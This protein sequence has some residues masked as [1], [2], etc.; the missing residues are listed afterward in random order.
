MITHD[1]IMP[2]A[3]A[4]TPNIDELLAPLN[5]VIRDATPYWDRYREAAKVQFCEWEGQSSDGRMW[6]KRLG[7]EPF[8]WDGAHDLRIR[9]ANEVVDETKD[10][11]LN[12]F[13][14]AEVQAV[15]HQSKGLQASALAT[16]TLRWLL[17]TQ[18]Q[19]QLGQEL[20]LAAEWRQGFGSAV[21]HVGW[22]RCV[23]LMPQEMSLE[24]LLAQSMAAQME[25]L[26]PEYQQDPQ[27][28]QMVQ[29]AA[30]QSV[31]DFR[32]SLSDP[33]QLEGLAASMRLTLL[34]HLTTTQIRAVLEEVRDTGRGVYP[35]PQTYLSQPVW[36]ALRPL[37][38][39]FFPLS[40]GDLSRS[41]WVCRM[42]YYNTDQLQERVRTEEWDQAW[43][44]AVVADHLGREFSA[45]VQ[46]IRD[47]LEAAATEDAPRGSAHSFNLV[48]R[49]GLAQVLHIYHRAVDPKG[50]P[51]VRETILHGSIQN[52]VAIS[53]NLPYEH[54][55]MPFVGFRRET[56]TR[57]LVE[58]RGIVEICMTHQHEVKR[59]RDRRADRSDLTTLPPVVL[60]GERG[61]GRYPF[62]PGS[63]INA[64]RGVT[65]EVMQFPQMDRASLEVEASV[66]KDVDRLFGRWSQD[67]PEP[68]I[69]EKQQCEADDWLEEIGQC[70]SQTFALAQQ[71]LDPVVVA[72]VSGD[73][74]AQ[75]LK[76][77][78]E[79]IQGRYDFTWRVDV[80]DVN[81][82][83]LKARLDVIVGL[84]GIDNAGRLDRGE[85]LNYALR[86]LDPHLAGTV[87]RPGAEVNQRERAEEK[88]ALAQMMVG[89]EPD[90]IEGQDHA[91]RLQVLQEAL[92]T[93]PMVQQTAQQN[94]LFAQLLE[95]RLKHHQ[96]MLQQQANA[97][98]GR[99]GVG[100]I[101][102]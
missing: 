4:E 83:F 9:L 61:G 57:A 67:V 63:Q 53:R 75:E 100:Q 72:R 74:A 25:Q 47:E 6:A 94:E 48:E 39:V 58:S 60:Q 41:P 102:Q 87:L 2:L 96:F 84:L 91:T 17:H 37:V 23:R 97:Q 64:R 88:A 40:V 20:R 69:I 11:L 12:A 76:V 49:E 92:Q 86:S 19:P 15:A 82:E 85:L 93:N 59:Q 79:E 3:Y 51:H 16:S 24:Q 7:R 13:R 62:R 33:D 55:Q 14:R 27:A 77:S 30:L 32:E 36:T 5:Q 42:A 52:A 35:E 66:R 99:V 18:M 80:R 50:F 43:V 95:N 46:Q 29:A 22:E 70:S 98:I 65:P 1:P 31:E 28:Q 45:D 54:G 56:K 73:V 8:P 21:M 68:V 101:M 44:N 34:P 71:Y 26:P 81:T 90:L 78:R 89:V 38:D 10:R